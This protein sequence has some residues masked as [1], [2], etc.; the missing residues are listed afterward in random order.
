MTDSGSARRARR[1]WDDVLL[2]TVASMAMI[3]QQVAG[4]AT[5]DALFLTQ[6]SVQRLPDMMIAGAA[7]SFGAAIW[8]ARALARHGPRKVV[9]AAFTA[10]AAAFAAE[11]AISWVSQRSIALIVYAH[12]AL[13]GATLISLFW[14]LVNERFDPHAAKPAVARIAAG[15]TLGG[16]LGGAIGW[17]I[18]SWTSV[19]GMLVALAVLNLV[20][21]AAVARMSERRVS[22]PSL[23]PS[24]P[25]EPVAIGSGLRAM[26]AEPYLLT[27]GAMVAVL[28]LVE[29]L[30]DWSFAAQARDRFVTGRSLMAFFSAFHMVVSILTFAA[31][32]MLSRRSLERFGLA[33]TMMAAPLVVAMLAGAA[34]D[35]P[36]LFAI[37]VL[38]GG[39][40]V[41][42]NSLWR[43]AY[44]LL[45]TPVAQEKKRPTKTL[46][47]VGCDRLGTLLGAGLVIVT[48]RLGVATVAVLVLVLV[49]AAMAIV[50][51]RLLQSGYVAAL[52][53]SLRTGAVR[54]EGPEVFEL[55]TR[56]TIRAS[57]LRAPIASPPP[58]PPPPP[59]P[60]SDQA[61]AEGDRL[62]AAIA[63]LRSRERRRIQ[64]V[65]CAADDDPR[66]APFVLPLLGR[67]DVR[68]EA[69]AWLRRLA[70]RI[71][72]QLV[73]A[74]VDPA[75]DP[76]VQRRIPRVLRAAG[77]QVAVDGLV[78]A[79][80]DDRFEVRYE[81]GLSL[82]R[83]VERDPSLAVASEPIVAAVR[84]ELA[85]ERRILEAEPALDLLD[86]DGDGPLFDPGLRDR[87]SRGLEHV[88]TILA[89]MLDREQLRTAFRALVA[90]D[91]AL[92]GTALEYLENVLPG[93]MRDALWPYVT[94]AHRPTR[95]GAR[96]AQEVLAELLR[97]EG[98]L[99]ALRG[100]RE[101]LA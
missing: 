94:G 87:A 15:G 50:L 96:S 101:S 13:F 8:A 40:A 86:D 18:A 1:A 60:P 20:A 10:S 69:V 49:F 92:R 43:S 91:D 7:V 41:L 97:A 30:V 39:E 79:L 9:R 70:P 80:A 42:A 25:P 66:L 17:N 19:R 77:S 44:E 68:S 82:A 14:S 73:D 4:K 6:F 16:V 21:L 32:A 51:A 59:A 46:I 2:A 35:T 98:P 53:E 26:R 63:D 27:L 31:Q 83:M 34:I 71:T 33:G 61:A 5:R 89:L 64:R 90:G 48:L 75:T 24:K 12:M 57:R 74:L 72:G 95:R 47:D 37:V 52:E 28:A 76:D 65:L 45:Y 36:G 56:R 54:V 81:C 100:R 3:A 22:A 85:V 99:S 78:R 29:A 11:F 62:L 93:E 84:R 55:T 23:A 58:T 88:F 67:A 38:R